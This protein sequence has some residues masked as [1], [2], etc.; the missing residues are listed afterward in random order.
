MY[1]KNVPINFNFT[2]AKN[3]TPKTITSIRIV[4]PDKSFTAQIS[5][6]VELP[7]VTTEG[8][9]AFAY[10]PDIIGLY[11]VLVLDDLADP[12]T[13]PEKVLYTFTF[14]VVEHNPTYVTSIS[15]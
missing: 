2:R 5:P 12:A 6:T 3:S 13:I 14:N 4:K 7:T 10:T 11:T 1:T 8:S 9:L 15:I